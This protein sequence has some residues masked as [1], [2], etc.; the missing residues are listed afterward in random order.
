MSGSAL[1]LVGSARPSGASTSEA[2]GAYLLARLE[3]RGLVT[4]TRFVSRSA[5][6]HNVTPLLYDCEHADLLLL[7]APVYVDAL[8]YL[9]TRALEQI[10]DHHNRRR[11]RGEARFAAV[12]NC[13]FPE[14]HQCETALGICR[15]FARH[16]GL[17]WAGGLALGGGGV[18][19]GRR[20]QG[21]GMATRHVRT[22]LE[23]AA[24][25]LADG[26]DIPD[27]AVDL[28]ARPVVPARLYTWL[29]ELDWLRRAR[30]NG[31]LA[32][33]GDRPFE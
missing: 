21:A 2:L 29:A 11:P 1:L 25:A 24:N 22:A 12:L 27:E 31:A 20:L 6:R 16:A 30:R 17:E 5:R 8:P 26:L 14:V 15:S 28:M 13:G 4:A 32:R 23:L 9:A 33:L 18:I 19:N 3:E 10:A 7:A